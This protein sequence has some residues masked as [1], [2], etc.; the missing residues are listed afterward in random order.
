MRWASPVPRGLGPSVRVFRPGHDVQQV[1]WALCLQAWRGNGIRLFR[2]PCGTL[3][4][5]A[6]G[7]HMESRMLAR[8]APQLFATYVQPQ[9]LDVVRDLKWA[10]ARAA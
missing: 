2:W 5:V 10:K 9:M 1:A 6:V 7:A 8:C 4:L 3:A